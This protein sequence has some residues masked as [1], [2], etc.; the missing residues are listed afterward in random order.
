MAVTRVNIVTNSAIRDQYVQGVL[1]LKQEVVVVVNDKVTWTNRGDRQHTAH[2][3]VK[4]PDGNGGVRF[5][6]AETIDQGTSQ[7]HTFTIDDYNKARASLGI[8]DGQPVHLGYYC[9]NHPTTMGGKLVLLKSEDDKRRM[10]K[11]AERHEAEAKKA[12]SQ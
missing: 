8:T 7:D 2:S 9:A 4:V 11:A 5:L 1:A 10:M 3:D 6:F 12:S